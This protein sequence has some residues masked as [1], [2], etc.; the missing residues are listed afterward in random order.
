MFCFCFSLVRVVFSCYSF[1]HLF[2]H[3]LI[4][5]FFYLPPLIPNIYSPADFLR[6][7]TITEASLCYFLS[8]SNVR[9]SLIL[10]AFPQLA[11]S[12]TLLISSSVIS[13][14]SCNEAFFFFSSPYLLLFVSFFSVYFY[15]SL[16]RIS[17]YYLSLFFLFG[18]LPAFILLLI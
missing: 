11:H 6:T 14:F 8:D 7:L 9:L 3:L 12:P 15:F 1:I 18:S 10:W 2:I 5:Y 4:Y 13:S 16:L 17:I